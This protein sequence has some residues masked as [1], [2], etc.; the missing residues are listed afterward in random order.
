MK[1]VRWLGR[2]LKEPVEIPRIVATVL[3][4]DAIILLS[5]PFA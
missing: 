4:L 5:R 1:A 3:V 2:W